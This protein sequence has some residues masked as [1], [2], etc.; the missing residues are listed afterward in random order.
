MTLFVL[1]LCLVLLVAASAM[2]IYRLFTGP[3][4]L[5]RILGFDMCA[6]C[7]I[8][9]IILLSVYWRTGVF[10]EILLIFSLLGFV[11]SVAFVSYLYGNPE[12]IWHKMRRP[13]GKGGEE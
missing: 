7:I 6:I 13:S 1:P 2:A 5:D 10:I 12:R 11:G 3:T 9:M 4:L 8:G